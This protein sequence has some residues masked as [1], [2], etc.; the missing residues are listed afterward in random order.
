[1]QKSVEEV[2]GIVSQTG[3]NLNVVG[4]GTANTGGN[5]VISYKQTPLAGEEVDA[6]SVI[7]VEFRRTDGGE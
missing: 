1:M 2:T 6:G 5:S 3:L 7:T 4:V